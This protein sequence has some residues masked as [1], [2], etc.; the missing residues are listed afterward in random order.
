MDNWTT[1]TK[2]I[3]GGLVGVTFFA[4]P[5]VIARLIVPPIHLQ[6]LRGTRRR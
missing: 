5:F 3:V 2:V 6:P 1:T 4:L